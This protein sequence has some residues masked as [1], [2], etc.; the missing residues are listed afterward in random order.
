MPS[1]IGA[2]L[3]EHVVRELQRVGEHDPLHRGVRDVPLVPQRDVLEPR[4][5]GSPRSTRARPQ[6]CSHFT[7]LRLWG[8]ALEPFCAPARKG[9]STSL[10]SVRWR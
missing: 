9:S 8:I 3:H 5:A 6:S 1:T 2:E 10:T 4:A 7:G